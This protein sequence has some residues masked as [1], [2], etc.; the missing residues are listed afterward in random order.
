MMVPL[1]QVISEHP[2][3]ANLEPRFVQTITDCASN[4]EYKAGHVLFREGDAADRF[5]LIRHGLVAVES[6][7]LERG[8]IVIDKIGPGDAIGYSWLVP[9]FKWHY[10]GR[11]LAPTHA[12]VIHADCLREKIE[13][14]PEL[15]YE[16][17]KRFAEVLLRR[18]EATRQQMLDAYSYKP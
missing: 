13:E 10:D 4:V 17:L 18:L 1:S 14:T 8:P 6:F 3:F 9:P 12:L 2:F 11:T 16:L 7:H 5:F 15:G